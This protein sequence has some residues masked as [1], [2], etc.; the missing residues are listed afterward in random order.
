M[1]YLFGNAVIGENKNS[2]RYL[3]IFKVHFNKLNN[4]FPHF[5]KITTK[6]H[7]FEKNRIFNSQLYNN[8]YIF[9]IFHAILEAFNLI[10]NSDEE[11]VYATFKD[12]NINHDLIEVIKSKYNHLGEYIDIFR[13]K[14]NNLGDEF[15][16]SKLFD[17]YIENFKSLVNCTK[18][19]N[20]NNSFLDGIFEVILSIY[21]ILELTFSV[22]EEGKAFINR[23]TDDKDYLFYISKLLDCDIEILKKRLISREIRSPRGSFYVIK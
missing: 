11:T 19:L 20:L 4:K 23:S 18:D 15:N 6:F 21:M 7:L 9:H 10:L 14:Y 13:K 1:V 5:T 12:P 22:D 8:Y 17:I 3:R 16:N 2:S